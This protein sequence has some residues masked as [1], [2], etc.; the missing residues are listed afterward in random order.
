MMQRLGKKIFTTI[1]FVAI[2]VGSFFVTPKQILAAEFSEKDLK[3]I[4]DNYS[5]NGSYS[6]IPC[7]SLNNGDKYCEA[8]NIC[9]VDPVSKKEGCVNK[10]DFFED[11]GFKGQC[12]LSWVGTGNVDLDKKG[13]KGCGCV[14]PGGTQCGKVYIAGHSPVTGIG[15][16]SFF[17]FPD[18]ICVEQKGQPFINKFQCVLS[19]PILAIR[20]GGI[21]GQVS[22]QSATLK[23]TKER[24]PWTKAECESVK[25][26]N[27]N[28]QQYEWIPPKSDVNA[29]V[30]D[31]CYIKQISTKLQVDIGSTGAIAG[32]PLYINT[33]YKYALG[34]GVIV[35]IV[36]I[37]FSGIQ[38]MLSGAVSSINTS[39]DRIKN[40]ALG[41]LLLFGA[42]TLLYTINPQLLNLKVPPMHAIRPEKFNVAQTTGEEG[43]RCDPGEA[44]ACADKGPNFKCKPTAYYAS[45]KC[46]SQA[47][48]FM[49]V[50][51]GGAAIAAAGPFIVSAG[52]TAI[53]QQGAG[54]IAKKIAL[55]AAENIAVDVATSGKTAV[56]ENTG[57]AV[58]TAGGSKTKMIL[59]GIAVVAGLAIADNLYSDYKEAQ[60]PANGYCVEMKHDL[61]DFSVCQADGDCASDKCL[62]TS[63]GACG[64][65]KFG[66][67]TSGKLRQ[68]CIIPKNYTFGLI[69]AAGNTEDA[70]KF[71]C[72]EGSCV[73]NNRGAAK[74]GVGICSDGSDI[75]LP[76]ADDVTCKSPKNNL[77]CSN[78]FCREKGFFG[79][80]GKIDGL[81]MSIG[82]FKPRCMLPTDCSDFK[83]VMTANDYQG[84]YVIGCLKMPV[85]DLNLPGRLLVSQVNQKIDES[86][87]RELSTYGSCVTDKP[88][89][90][91]YDLSSGDPELLGE[92]AQPCYVNFYPTSKFDPDSK[93]VADYLATK[94]SMPTGVFSTFDIK[95]V[96]C[97]KVG[98]CAI[99]PSDIATA[100]GTTA[101]KSVRGVCQNELSTNAKAAIVKDSVGNEKIGVVEPDD[102]YSGIKFPNVIDLQYTNA[103]AAQ[104]TK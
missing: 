10:G 19:A 78:G 49:A 38:W 87:Y 18:S 14:S 22:S 46:L 79:T 94:Q 4:N 90:K 65:G 84:T 59:G 40:A 58:L 80:S 35:M 97:G 56:A 66:V 29:Q 86:F 17:E 83:S 74:D 7:K 68:A 101:F 52:A 98:V 45:S 93:T 1:F 39:K 102:D 60:E 44:N 51:V 34:I 77:E 21:S 85:P 50:A 8:P 36:V 95:K 28:E 9:V 99:K 96:G 75:G 64:A 57:S 5:L 41:L 103:G 42:N 30:G 12:S 32:L 67:C 31:Y 6:W 24:T 13:V 62:I 23:V 27:S 72:N 70:K 91:Q 54:Q 61:P 89:F 69:D 15:P 81:V 100:P 2:A 82:D 104:G 43:V 71:N 25:Q 16:E 92:I 47:N 37:V 20:S 63:V 55:E 76:C 26:A 73:D 33:A 3:Y 48:G 88:K 11:D 53:A